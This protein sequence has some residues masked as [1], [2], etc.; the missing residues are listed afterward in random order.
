M[1]KVTINKP[2]HYREG[3]DVKRY[4]ASDEEV[5]VSQAVADHA[6]SNGFLAEKKPAEANKPVQP[7]QRGREPLSAVD[8][9]K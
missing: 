6:K 4:G 5:E 1:P 7:P 8:E 2:F 9:A 3:G